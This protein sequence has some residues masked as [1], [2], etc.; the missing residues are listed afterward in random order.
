MDKLNKVLTY[1]PTG[2]FSGGSHD[3]LE[4]DI[5]FRSLEK[6]ALMNAAKFWKFGSKVLEGTLMD[7]DCIYTG[8]NPGSD[9]AKKLTDEYV[10]ACDKSA[11]D[12]SGLKYR[13]LAAI[14]INKYD[15]ECKQQLTAFN[16]TAEVV[17]LNLYEGIVKNLTGEATY[18]LS[19]VSFNERS[20]LQ[21]VE[22]LPLLMKKLRLDYGEIK[23]GRITKLNNLY[24]KLMLSNCNPKKFIEYQVRL[25]G[26]INELNETLQKTKLEVHPDLTYHILEVMP[27]LYDSVVQSLRDDI[28]RYGIKN[29]PIIAGMSPSVSITPKAATGSNLFTKAAIAAGMDKG[30]VSIL[31]NEL[32]SINIKHKFEIE[33]LTKQLKDSRVMSK[34]DSEL[35][36][37]VT[38][39]FVSEK[40]SA[41]YYELITAGTIKSQG[42]ISMSAY[43]TSAPGISKDSNLRIK[44]NNKKIPSKC[45][46]CEG[47][48][49][50]LNACPTF[51]GA[52]LAGKIDKNARF[53]S[54]ACFICGKTGHLMRE[55]LLLDNPDTSEPIVS[56]TKIQVASKSKFKSAGT[57]VI[58]NNVEY[59]LVA[60]AE[61]SVYAV[62]GP[63]DYYVSAEWLADTCAGANLAAD[64]NVFASLADVHGN[65]SG[66][67]TL[68]FEGIGCCILQSILPD[69]VINEIRLSTVYYCPSFDKNVF[70]GAIALQDSA[71][72]FDF[73]YGNSKFIDNAGNNHP[74]MIRNGFPV[75]H[76]EPKHAADYTESDIEFITL[77][78]S[79]IKRNLDRAYVVTGEQLEKAVE[80]GTVDDNEHYW[81]VFQ[82]VDIDLEVIN[83]M[84][85]DGE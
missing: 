12:S 1:T 38:I 81:K 4:V 32:D 67:G 77:A 57:Y 71:A 36:E 15:F 70:G 10:A 19:D 29:D 80:I 79:K 7:S 41:H 11:K 52:R 65:I 78:T 24:N 84:P 26:L 85:L 82:G 47:N 39:S 72:H 25:M 3:N 5:S 35:S 59:A 8:Y 48:F 23:L 69:G 55:C 49:H 68:S 42:D 60:P 37:G 56:N 17:A 6:D 44:D 43:F 45:N 31:A 64:T 9:E 2:K 58:N 76:W 13:A 20:G 30:L 50:R 66:V 27:A 21:Y 73:T 33:E 28:K 34:L 14:E 16:E 18:L 22:R 62:S 53:E 63:L 74:I 75:F 83:N 61:P 54:P 40:L 51:A 46:L